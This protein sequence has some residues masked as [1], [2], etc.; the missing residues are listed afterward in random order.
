[1]AMVIA[2]KATMEQKNAKKLDDS[3]TSAF[4]RQ[5][6]MDTLRNMTPEEAF[7]AFDND[8]DGLIT[9]DEFRK[10]L[11]YLAIKISDAKALRYFKMCDIG[12]NNAIDI[13][14][15]RTAMFACDPTNGNSAGFTPTRQ[16][17]PLD[18][19]ETFD[20][21]ETGFIDE[22]EFYFAMQ[23]LGYTM[24]DGKH[25]VAFQRVD[26]NN[27][28]SIDWHEFRNLFVLNCDVRKELEDRNVELA[29]IVPRKT[30]LQQ[31]RSILLDEEVRERRAIAE[32][33]RN[34]LWVF[35]IREKKRFLQEAHF[36][37]YR[38]LRTA[39]DAAGQVYVFGRG[40]SNQFDDKAATEIKTSKFKFE[41]LDRLAEL[42]ND[43]VIPQQLV[44]KFRADRQQQVA[45]IKRDLLARQKGMAELSGTLQVKAP[46]I[47]NDRITI[48]PYEEGL[49]SY[50]H[51]NW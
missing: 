28:G 22:D 32:A 39:I 3:T 11:P 23:Y 50:F 33:L 6:I 48:D 34:K 36:R 8:D 19:F 24:D 14:E 13:D 18:A 31:L 41:H 2:K 42:W 17:S 20:E 44:N 49:A 46:E 5:Q 45:E 15:F 51:G 40:T 25:E 30:M 12:G 27:T 26:F 21:D 16:V 47:K 9:F 43:R 10:L 29:T 37:S 38:E 1:M 35:L 7:L 4:D